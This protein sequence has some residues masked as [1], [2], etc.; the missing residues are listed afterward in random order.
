MALKVSEAAGSGFTPK[1][2]ATPE[3]ETDEIPF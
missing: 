2:V 3:I 1:P